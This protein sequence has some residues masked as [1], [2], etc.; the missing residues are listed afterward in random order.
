MTRTTVLKILDLVWI[1]AS[2]LTQKDVVAL[3]RCN[4]F[5]HDAVVPFLY[6]NIDVSIYSIRC[7]ADILRK[8]VTLTKYFRRLSLTLKGKAPPN[9]ILAYSSAG[10]QYNGHS[11][12]IRS[13]T[14]EGDS[15]RFGVCHKPMLKSWEAR[16][17]LVGHRSRAH[18]DICMVDARSGEGKCLGTID[19]IIEKIS[20][21]NR[22]TWTCRFKW[23]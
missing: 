21:Y 8:N 17:L 11:S 12:G 19:R 9:Q 2:N 3:S 6:R 7:L 15:R 23:H 18:K 4:W 20:I 1:V 13:S 16:A 10:Q 5:L 22:P 14:T